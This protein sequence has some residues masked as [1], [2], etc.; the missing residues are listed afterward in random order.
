VAKEKGLVVSEEHRRNQPANKAVM[1][2]AGICFPVKPAE[3]DEIMI[4]RRHR[5]GMTDKPK[6]VA[7]QSARLPTQ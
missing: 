2:P 1:M 5:K 6:L 4:K 3:P 7:R